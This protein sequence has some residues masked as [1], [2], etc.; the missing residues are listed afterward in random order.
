MTK[1]G[2]EHVRPFGRRGMTDYELEKLITGAGFVEYKSEPRTF[3]NIYPD[4]DTLLASVES[5]SFG[6]F[7]A[8][9]SDVLRASMRIAL[10]ELLEPKRLD[11]RSIQLERYLTITTARK[12]NAAEDT[13]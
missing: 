2:A 9:S 5:A 12:A 10:D 1:I 8:S 6:N 7:L 4:V 11:D 3:V 13:V